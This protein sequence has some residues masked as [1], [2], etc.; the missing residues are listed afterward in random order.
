MPCLLISLLV[1][2]FLLDKLVGDRVPE[3]LRSLEACVAASRAPLPLLVGFGVLGGAGFGFDEPPAVF[4]A[5]KASVA[6]FRA[7]V[8][9]ASASCPVGVGLD[10]ADGP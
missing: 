6:P 10:K 3:P 9:A 4:W 5:W 7:A 8:R 1:P 2:V